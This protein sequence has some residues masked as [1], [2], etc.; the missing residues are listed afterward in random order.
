MGNL[1]TR[2]CVECSN[3]R[4]KWCET[5]QINCLKKNFANWTSKNEQIDE[6]IKSIQDKH[7]IFEWIPYYQFDDINELIN[8]T[9]LAKWR[10]GPL[11][12]SYY[13][14][15]NTRV[16]SSTKVIL[17][18]LVSSQNI[19]EFINKIIAYYN[20]VKVYGI[21]QNPDTKY[22]IIIFNKNHENKQIDNLIQEMQLKIN[23]TLF[24]QWIPYYQFY[25]ISKEL[26]NATYSARLGMATVGHE[27]SVT[28][29]YLVNPQN[30]TIELLDKIIANY[31]KVKVYGISQ[32]P[33]T[34]YYIIIFNRNQYL[35]NYC[36][37]CENEN[38]Q[39]NN[40][41]QEIMLKINDYNDTIFEW[42][43][44]YQIVDIKDLS[45]KTHSAK[46][47]EIKCIDKYYEMNRDQNY[48][49]YKYVIVPNIDDKLKNDMF[50]FV[51]AN[52][53]LVQEQAN[54]FIAQSHPQAYYTSRKLTEILIQEGSQG[55][56]C[57]YSI[58]H[59][60]TTCGGDINYQAK[61]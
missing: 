24:T 42:I 36:V 61:K 44:Y 20:E 27:V 21:Y 59:N 40:I 9:H 41:I 6:L 13:N 25:K 26:Y 31:N 8:E 23:D 14:K 52:K 10:D 1:L 5:C 48:K 58:D 60:M 51:E 55:F 33:D 11:L 15:T 19:N 3:T 49:N 12:R 30:N 22:Y 45:N 17:K 7:T 39:I 2:E 28:L 50:E 16:L 47:K 37:K 38:K 56:D 54:T 4:H 32:D 53:T 57:E 43:P 35:K 46:W 18:Y 29:K 34:K